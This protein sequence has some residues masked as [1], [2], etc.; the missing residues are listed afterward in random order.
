MNKKKLLLRSY[1]H[2]LL[3]KR[4][5]DEKELQF[6]TKMIAKY[7]RPFPTDR[8]QD[9]KL[10]VEFKVLRDRLSFAFLMFNA[11]W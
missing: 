6:W 5:L 3:M 4:F 2:N 7:L 9:K 1:T 11:L 10:K 8:R